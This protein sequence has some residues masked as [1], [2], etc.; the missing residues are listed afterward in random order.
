M[1]LIKLAQHSKQKDRERS[2]RKV[3]LSDRN[4]PQ[5]CVSLL[6]GFEVYCQTR[7]FTGAVHESSINTLKICSRRSAWAALSPIRS[8]L[9]VSI[10]GRA[11]HL[12]GSSGSSNAWKYSSVTKEAFSQ[13]VVR[14]VVYQHKRESGA[15]S[16]ESRLYSVEEFG[17]LIEIF[18]HAFFGIPSSW[19]PLTGA[20]GPPRAAL[21]A[22][23]PY[24]SRLP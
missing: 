4:P 24:R 21:L 18:K 3:E 13:L 12:V 20:C 19:Y 6:L 23:L 10:L 22:R 5:S 9:N 7:L 14:L 15:L 11:K 8:H 17:I 2:K 1:K 16:L